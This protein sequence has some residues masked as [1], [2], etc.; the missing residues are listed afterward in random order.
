MTILTQGSPW[1]IAAARAIL[2]A[3]IVGG[4]GFLAVWQT[5]DDTKILIVSGLTPFLT[6]LAMRLGLE[7]YVDARRG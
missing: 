5:T 7:G 1:K 6:T 2:S 3:L 4:L